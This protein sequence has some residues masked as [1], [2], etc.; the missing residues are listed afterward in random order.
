[1]KN[2]TDVAL[3]PGQALLGGAPPRFGL[4]KY[5]RQ[6][7]TIPK[8]H[9]LE[10]GGDTARTIALSMSELLEDQLQERTSDLHCVTTWT[11]TGL[12]W[13]G[14]P[15][16]QVWQQ[17]QPVIVPD[18]GVAFVVARGL[19]GFATS[20]PLEEALHE[21]CLLASHLNGEPLTHQHG[22]PL[23]LVLP[24]LY[25][26]KSVKHLCRLEFTN[27]PLPTKVTRRFLIHPRGRVD[28]EERSSVG[29]QPFWR[30]LYR[31][32]LPRFMRM[33]EQGKHDEGNP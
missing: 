31:S 2:S 12:R 10:V 26:Y 24:Q 20:I 30:W 25:G 15:F 1:M 5:L 23:R 13:S 17:L 29:F 6:R 4:P 9:R 8:D 18:A 16:R 33:A 19:D 28:L 7:V 27:S 14:R 3:P 11:A 22:A 21:D 32:Q